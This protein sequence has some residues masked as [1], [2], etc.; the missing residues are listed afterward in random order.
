MK[1]AGLSIVE[2]LVAAL[3]AALI[4]SAALTTAATCI[5]FHTDMQQKRMARLILYNLITVSETDLENIS[6]LQ[7]NEQGKPDPDGI[8]QVLV[9]R[10][11]SKAHHYECRVSYQNREGRSIQY[12]FPK[13]YGGPM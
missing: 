6:G 10:D 7:L 3:I 13:V 4:A 2:A 5:A 8:Y 1:K 12:A 9:T 11:E